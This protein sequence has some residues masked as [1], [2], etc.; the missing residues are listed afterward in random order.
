M[1]LRMALAMQ[2]RNVNTETVRQACG[3]PYGDLSLLDLSNG[4]RQ[5]GFKTVSL[6]LDSA[7]QFHALTLPAIAH[8]LQN[9]FILILRANDHTLLFA[10][11][12]RGTIQLG[13]DEFRKFWLLDE[14]MSVLCLSP[15]PASSPTTL[16]PAIP[17][18]SHIP[19]TDPLPRS[20]LS[21]GFGRENILAL[22]ES[23]A[24]VL[25]LHASGW[26]MHEEGMK[27][28]DLMK[29]LLMTGMF[30]FAW[31]MAYLA[32][33]G[34]ADRR[35]GLGQAE[36]TTE[37]LVRRLSNWP[38]P[39]FAGLALSI[40]LSWIHPVAG[41]LAVSGMA[42]TLLFGTSKGSVF[43]G[44]YF[45]RAAYPHG[46]ESL[47]AWLGRGNKTML[48][49]WWIFWT[50]AILISHLIR[51]LGFAHLAVVWAGGMAIG[52]YLSMFR[53]WIRTWQL[54]FMLPPRT[55]RHMEDPESLPES[56]DLDYYLESR[57]PNPA[58]L[59]VPHGKTTLLLGSQENRR[60]WI[61]RLTA[62]VADAGSLLSYGKVPISKQN[63]A[64]LQRRI[65]DIREPATLP[66]W[67]ADQPNGTSP[68]HWRI[69]MDAL[70]L[71]SAS[72]LPDSEFTRAKQALLTQLREDPEI[73][74]L[75]DGHW[76]PDPFKA[77]VLLENIL[78]LR[79][80]RTTVIG[81]ERKEL[82][83]SADHVLQPGPLPEVHVSDP[84]NVHP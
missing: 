72:Q 54:R 26:L 42:M 15:L 17:A 78:E 10:D 55:P 38:R 59:H 63:R 35:T 19:E 7:G 49:I 84:A 11:P 36:T 60:A 57:V 21:I 31:G 9:H 62:R 47:T 76:E 58:I 5:L 52:L 32:R 22:V 56:G 43:R 71:S 40:Y 20:F 48:A 16:P 27:W 1:A 64:G 4:A 24:M 2:G 53:E 83:P 30:G 28:G 67:S 69:W 12:A 25:F 65:M 37:V 23:V 44:R 75:E 82:I 79:R 3:V 73:L 33:A 61:D 45:T 29:G 8:V 50:L 80:G 46:K 6:R 14:P 18:S 34:W 70:L 13:W 39:V 68:E 66:K 81:T 51:P 74:V 77:L 41:G